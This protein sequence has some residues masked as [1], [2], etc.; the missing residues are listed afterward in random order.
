M[1]IFS[2][3]FVAFHLV[4]YSNFFIP[5]H[6]YLNPM[7]PI[8]GLFFTEGP[9]LRIL[10]SRLVHYHPPQKRPLQIQWHIIIIYV[11]LMDIGVGGVWL[12]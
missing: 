12:I 8:L 11:I 6:L 2:E 10:L 7:S 3:G 1:T 5:H 4:F 9:H